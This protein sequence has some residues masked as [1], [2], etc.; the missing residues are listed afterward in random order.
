M[1]SAPECAASARTRSS[2]SLGAG[3]MGEVYRARDSR[4]GRDVAIKVLPARS[5]GRPGRA[6]PVR[7]RSA[8]GGGALASQHPRHPRR[9]RGRGTSSTPSWSCSRARRCA[10]RLSASADRRARKAVDYALQI[11]RGPRRRARPRHRASRPQARER[12]PDRRRPRQDPRLRPGACSRPARRRTSSSRSRRPW[13]RSGH[14]PRHPGYMSPEQVRG[15]KVDQRTDLFALGAI[16]YE[17]L[18]GRRAFQ[19]QSPAETMLAV[20][21]EDPMASATSAQDLPRNSRRIVSHCLEKEPEE[22]F[23]SARDLG[24]ALTAWESAATPLV[25]AGDLGPRR[26]RRGLHRGSSLPQ[27]ERRRGGRVLLRRN[28]GGD[29]QRAH[30]HRPDAGRRAHLLV[31][32]QGQG[33]GRPRRS[34]GSSACATV[35][36]GSVRKAGRRLRITAQLIDVA[37]GYQLWSER[38][39]REMEDVFADPGRD[40]EGD[41]R[42][43]ADPARPGKRTA[44]APAADERPRGIRRVSEGPVRLEPA[45]PRR[46]SRSS[47]PRWIATPTTRPPTSRLADSYAIWA[48]TGGSRAGGVRPRARRRENAALIEPDSAGVHLSLG[49]IEHYYGWDMAAKNAS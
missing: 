13:R 46:P 36:E 21:Q 7:P 22:R 37:S 25:R 28:H 39:D 3:G 20:L 14:R 29:H 35:L 26:A 4:L 10:T 27:H 1:L 6:G 17:M 30:G 9:R 5:G 42:D 49:I 23:Q 38:Y 34:A 47:A 31:R 41:R 19:A 43:A 15:R 16:L 45:P 32:L 40:R 18:T 12:L 2:E 48:S 33:H 24:F 8:G 44:G 11:A